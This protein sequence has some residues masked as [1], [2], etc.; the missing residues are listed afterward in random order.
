MPSIVNIH[1][2]VQSITTLSNA[3]PPSVQKATV[4]DKIWAVIHGPEG[5]TPFETFNRR[6]DALF[7]E[8]CHDSAG[9]L[10]YL[11]RGKSGMGLVC[12]YI[13]KINWNPEFPLDLVEIKLQ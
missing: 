7:G 13:K 9:C 3:L 11:C 8:D 2:L 6:F 12:L 5:E 10:H 1:R 4:N